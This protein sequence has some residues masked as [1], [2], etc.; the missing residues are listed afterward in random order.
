MNRNAEPPRPDDWEC[1]PLWLQLCLVIRVWHVLPAG[2]FLRWV[3]RWFFPSLC[4]ISAFGAASR[5]VPP[6]HPI[7]TMT[8][9]AI[10]F[11]AATLALMALV[12]VERGMQ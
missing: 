4:F 7:A 6:G 2:R 3:D 1:L 10:S 8:V 9:L 11:M 12:P 5:Y